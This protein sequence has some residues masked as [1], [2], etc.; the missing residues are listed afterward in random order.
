VQ[1]IALS[2]LSPSL[3]PEAIVEVVN[4]VGTPIPLT[5]HTIVITGEP[6][7]IIIKGGR[8][9]SANTLIMRKPLIHKLL[10]DT[11]P[12]VQVVDIE[13]LILNQNISG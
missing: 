2:S 12:S 3:S 1:D 4:P 6:I 10:H 13:C 9:S 8:D 7:F 5:G 11:D